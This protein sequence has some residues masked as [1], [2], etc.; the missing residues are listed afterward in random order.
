M[1]KII[2]RA[3]G[4]SFLLIGATLMMNF[5][6]CKK[7]TDGGGT[8]TKDF[9]VEY[10]KV[11]GSTNLV[12]KD[13]VTVSGS[14]E[15][16]TL[17]VVVKNCNDY[18]L[19]YEL[20]DKK[21]SKETDSGKVKINPFDIERGKSDLTI[22]LIADGYN[23]KVFLIEIRREDSTTDV[24]VMLK[25]TEDAVPV[26]VVDGKNYPTSGDKATVSIVST[27]KAEFETVT[28]AG[29]AIT[30]NETNK[31]KVEKADVATNGNVEVKA[32]FKYYKDS[33][34]NFS[35]EKVA[36]GEVPVRVLQATVSS[37][38]KYETKKSLTFADEN[39]VPTASVELEDIEYSCV[40]LEMETDVALKADGSGLQECKDER[41]PNY[42]TKPMQ[43]DVKGIFSGRLIKE[44]DKDGKVTKEYNKSIEGKKLTEYLIIGAGTVEYKFKLKADDRKETECVVKITN[45]SEK[46]VVY[47]GN[48]AQFYTSHGYGI[49]TFLSGTPFWRW[50]TYSKLP[51]NSEEAFNDIANLEYMG[52]IVKMTFAKI[53]AGVEGDMYFYY[54][55]FDDANSKKHEFARIIG[56]PQG[57]AYFTQA[58]FN[59]EGKYVDAF[60]AFKAFLPQALLPLQLQKKWQKVVD[61]GFLFQIENGLK[62]PAPTQQD[63]NAKVSSFEIFYDAFN[64]R[65]QAKTYQAG[66]V[67]NI[68]LQQ[69]YADILTG[70]NTAIKH[71]FLH[72]GKVNKDGVE[73]AADLM[74]MVPTF[75]GKIGDSIASVKYTIKKN[76]AEEIEWKDV[77]LTAS[78]L[79]DFLCLNAKDANV[80]DKGKLK[81]LVSLYVYEKGPSN[82]NN[83]EIEVTITPKTGSAETFKYKIDYKNKQTVTSM[84]L[85]NSPSTDSNLF[86][87]P[88]SYAEYANREVQAMF[89]EMMAQDYVRASLISR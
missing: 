17:E 64:Y 27:G 59:P 82:E 49:E 53:N 40:K 77:T 86:G 65:V 26:E 70:A 37:G 11:W 85:E 33:T 36:P 84:S 25:R 3:I 43:N 68:G 66:S 4:A 5:L 1:K 23:K 73:K 61:K 46:K 38:N 47:E 81:D 31:K 80:D 52:D 72:G 54:N 13:K 79:D 71:P 78:K 76:G 69:D 42:S 28:I 83:Y 57:G 60:V 8:T 67:L 39:G 89:R 29:S 14:A 75:A 24:K 87:V 16:K 48:N 15:D 50:T 35:L 44:L 55:V 63:P 88:T 12:Q 51:V 58:R 20:N 30:I 62:Y 9:E 2:K 18:K 21:D 45:K 6:S 74:V 41:S 19:E 56:E 10:I 32:T 7:E 34:T 22:K